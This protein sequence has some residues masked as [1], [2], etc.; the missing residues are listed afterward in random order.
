MLS[1]AWF[2]VIVAVGIFWGLGAY[3]RLMRLRSQV[4]QSFDAL[5][6]QLLQFSELVQQLLSEVVSAPAA[7]W[8]SDLSQAQGLGHWSRLQESARQAAMALARMHEHPL[9]PDSV[10]Q[11]RQTQGELQ[12]AWE[13][14][15]EPHAYR[16]A[17]SDALQQRWQDQLLL[18]Q[19]DTERFNQAMDQYNQAIDEFP[20][21]LIARLY[22]FMPGRTL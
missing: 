20:A 9:Q 17:V 7:S 2:W 14:L 3:N 22:R 18:V 6:R 11:V 13:A 16:Q 10:E 4:Q 19:P 1:S 5:E 21:V 8:R 15:L 12:A